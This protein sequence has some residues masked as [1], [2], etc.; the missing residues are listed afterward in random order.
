MTKVVAV[1]GGRS[2]P[3]SGGRVPNS[4]LNREKTGNFCD[5]GQFDGILGEN[6]SSN[7]QVSCEFPKN[8]NREFFDW[9]RE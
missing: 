6:H 9:N 8:R 7:Q 1:Q 3:V 4:L 5:F 2:E